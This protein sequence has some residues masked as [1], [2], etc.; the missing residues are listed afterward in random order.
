MQNNIYIKDVYDVSPAEKTHSEGVN[1][2]D[3]PLLLKLQALE[4]ALKDAKKVRN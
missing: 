3:K 2:I 4:A 1:V